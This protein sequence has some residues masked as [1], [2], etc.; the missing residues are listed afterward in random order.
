L[1]DKADAHSHTVRGVETVSRTSHRE[2]APGLRWRCRDWLAVHLDELPEL[3]RAL[4]PGAGAGGE[5]VSGTAVPGLPLNPAA[6]EA[7]NNIRAILASWCDLVAERRGTAPTGRTVGELAGY[8]AAAVDWLAA[9]PAAGDTA[10]EVADFV[11]AARR[12]A[13]PTRSA[14]SRSTTMRSTTA[15][16]P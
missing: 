9:Y 6:V 10:D 15:P 2:T 11:H 7:R 13:T 5:K 4:L 12:V 14:A 3:E 8:L 16:A 1:A